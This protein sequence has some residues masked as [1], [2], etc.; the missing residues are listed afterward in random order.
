MAK[1]VAL[2]IAAIA[3]VQ[4]LLYQGERSDF[5]VNLENCGLTTKHEQMVEDIDKENVSL[6]DS[7]RIWYKG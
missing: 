5:A 7:L 1:N 6:S 2:T 4:K 3:M